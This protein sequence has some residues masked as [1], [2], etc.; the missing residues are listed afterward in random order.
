LNFLTSLELDPS[1]VE[2]LSKDT[3]STNAVEIEDATFQWDSAD[4]KDVQQTASL[5]NISLK[6]KKGSITAVVGTVGSGKSSILA[7]VLGDIP[8]LAG[9]VTVHGRIAYVAQDA[10]IQNTTLQDNIALTGMGRPFIQEKY[11]EAIDVC[12]LKRDIEI[13]PNGDQTE[14]GEKGINLSGGQK[15]RISLARAVYLDQLFISLT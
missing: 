6:V 12:Q 5:T 15:Q 9:K 13:L 2:V 14:I 10:W 3:V 7:A 11:Q 8:K 4:D 1:S